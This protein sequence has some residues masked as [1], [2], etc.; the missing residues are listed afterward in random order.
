[1]SI[2]DSVSLSSEDTLC[3]FVEEDDECIPG[4]SDVD[5]DGGDVVAFSFADN[6]S[7]DEPPA[8]R[9][10]GG[11]APPE[12]RGKHQ[13]WVFCI[14]NPTRDSDNH[15]KSLGEPECMERERIR[16]LVWGREVGESGTPH[17]QGYIHFA[18]ARV[19]SSAYEY[20]SPGLP[21]YLHPKDGTPQQASKY[22]KKDG[23]YDEFGELPVKGARSDLRE[24]AERVHKDGWNLCD[25][26]RSPTPDF[27]LITTAIRHHRHI[28]VLENAIGR[29]NCRDGSKDVEVIW[30]HGLPG[31]GK[32]RWAFETYPKAYVYAGSPG[33]LWF[34]NYN[35][36]D[37]I[38]IDDFRGNK[39]VGADMC[40]PTIDFSYLLRLLDRYPMQVPVK[41]GYKWLAATRFVITCPFSPEDAWCS[42][43]NIA[44]LTRRITTVKEFSGGIEHVDAQPEMQLRS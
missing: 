36:E 8:K 13:G 2:C 24:I 10:R 25:E 15:L 43:E 14:N 5:G 39:V 12:C 21:A 4:D 28:E 6:T 42:S 27:G 34:D 26:V 22:C 38:V 44:Q 1:M 30:C 7:T 9:R 29:S 18:S 20:V 33:C 41:G 19:W 17:L 31:S 16:Y 37:T 11:S 35:Y 40:K 3:D 23:D 32:S